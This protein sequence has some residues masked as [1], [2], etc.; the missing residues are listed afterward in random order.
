MANA[1][2][3]AFREILELHLYTPLYTKMEIAKSITLDPKKQKPPS[4]LDSGGS[5]SQSQL[6]HDPGRALF[7][8]N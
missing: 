8:G 7:T 6:T 4:S 2:Y 1:L 3:I 5:P